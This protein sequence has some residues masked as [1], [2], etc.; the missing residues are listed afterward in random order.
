MA[1]E[2]ICIVRGDV[3][4]ERFVRIVAGNAG[5]A[6]VAL[7]PTLAV[8]ETVGSEAHVEHASAN[9]EHLA[10]DDVLPCAMAGAAEIDVI[11]ASELSGIED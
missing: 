3:V 2:A 8:F 11:D 10:G 7:C 9:A 6:G 5:D 4:R 1:S